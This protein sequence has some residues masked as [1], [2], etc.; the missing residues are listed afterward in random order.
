MKYYIMSCVILVTPSS[1]N[2]KCDELDKTH[3]GY[4]HNPLRLSFSVLQSI[5]ISILTDVS[6][7][8]KIIVKQYGKNPA[9]CNI[10]IGVVFLCSILS[11]IVK[12][13]YDW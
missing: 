13:I 6:E 3:H 1:N 8:A 7:H 10:F 12:N 2:E 11:I 5:D 9:K 4:Q